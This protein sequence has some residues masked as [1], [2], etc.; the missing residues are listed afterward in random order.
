MEKFANKTIDEIN[1]PND[2][3]YKPCCEPRD[4]DQYDFTGCR[5]LFAKKDS[6]VLNELTN[7]EKDI[8]KKIETKVTEAT[9][10]FS[11]DF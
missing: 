4:A 2:D 7:E 6:S 5:W 1:D 3:C 11:S 8:W 9:H 10:P